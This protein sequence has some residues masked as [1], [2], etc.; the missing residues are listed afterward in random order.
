MLPMLQNNE[1]A[2]PSI[3]QEKKHQD[4]SSFFLQGL[5]PPFPKDSEASPWQSVLDKAFQDA[6]VVFIACDSSNAL[7]KGIKTAMS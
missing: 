1:E 4:H 2:P 7:K 3:Q 5:K 6:R